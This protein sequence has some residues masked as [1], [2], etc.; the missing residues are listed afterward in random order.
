M[1]SP[2]SASQRLEKFRLFLY[3]YHPSGGMGEL[4]K[5]LEAAWRARHKVAAEAAFEKAAREGQ[6][7]GAPSFFAKAEEPIA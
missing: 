6:T 5:K 4:P 1:Q 7:V 2:Y 3:S